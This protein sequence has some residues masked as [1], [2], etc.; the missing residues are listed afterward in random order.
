VPVAEVTDWMYFE[1]QRMKGNYSA[2]ALLTHE[3]PEAR[4]EFARTYGK[5]CSAP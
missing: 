1:G 2:C 5:D 4:A 3:P